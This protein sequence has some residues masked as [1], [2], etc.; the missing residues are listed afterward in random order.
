MALFHNIYKI[1]YLSHLEQLGR[2]AGRAAALHVLGDQSQ[3]VGGVRPEAGH[4]Q[5]P[6]FR[7]AAIGG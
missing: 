2:L 4:R 1:A 3:L 5:R 6:G 7:R